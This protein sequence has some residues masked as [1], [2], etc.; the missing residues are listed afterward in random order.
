M[1]GVRAKHCKP[2]QEQRWESCWDSG[3]RG[4]SGGTFE[5]RWEMGRS[6]PCRIL[7]VIVQSGV[8][9]QCY[10][11][12]RLFSGG[13]TWPNLC[14]Q[15]TRSGD[16]ATGDFKWKLGDRSREKDVCRIIA[17]VWAR[18]YKYTYMKNYVPPGFWEVSLIINGSMAAEWQDGIEVSYYTVE[19][20]PELWWFA[21]APSAW[22]FLFW[23]SLT[24]PVVIHG[25]FFVCFALLFRSMK[26]WLFWPLKLS[27]RGLP[28]SLC[29]SQLQ[30]VHSVSSCVLERE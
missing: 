26:L 4:G 29:R 28:L 6:Q 1:K 14:F 3:W 21:S 27:I 13:L 15:I 12:L 24:V 16:W 11:E 10:K 7:E 18:T 23:F 20:K 19:E 2:R 22:W 8:W 30:N 9:S 5:M 25:S 17:K